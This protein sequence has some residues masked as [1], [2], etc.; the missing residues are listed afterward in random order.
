MPNCPICHKPTVEAAKPFCSARCREVDLNK[1]FTASYAVP[2][3]ELDDVD[4]ESLAA[5]A[6]LLA[7]PSHE[8]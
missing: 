7:K 6:E 1:W 2:A 3:V 4:D 8:S 5:A